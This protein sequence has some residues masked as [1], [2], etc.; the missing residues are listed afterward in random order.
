MAERLLPAWHRLSTVAVVSAVYDV[1]LG[2]AMLAAPGV[3][4]AAFGVALPVPTLHAELNGLFLVAVG[5]GYILPLRRPD[6]GRLYLWVMGPFLKGGG[7]A[8][9][10]ADHV[11]RGSPASF[12]LFAA[13]DGSLAVATLWALLTTGKEPV[14]S[15][16]VPIAAAGDT[17]GRRPR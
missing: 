3:L 12:L 9:F 1:L 5:L 16:G 10:I 11:L 13:A 2:V 7:A 17:A 14:T 8:L 6:A 4:A 15:S